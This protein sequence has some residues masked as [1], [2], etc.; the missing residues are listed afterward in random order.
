MKDGQ[1][2][3]IITYGQG[4]MPPYAVQ[5]TQDD[6]WKIIAYI[7]SLQAKDAAAADR[8]GNE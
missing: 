5:V 2:F 4:N 7:R 3:H 1:L 6:R 8:E